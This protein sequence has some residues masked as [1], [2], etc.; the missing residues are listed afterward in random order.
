MPVRIVVGSRTK[1]K[2]RVQLSEIVIGE[3]GREKRKGSENIVIYDEEGKI[4]LKELFEKVNKT[5]TEYS[6]S[7]GEVTKY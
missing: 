6:K 4:D 5:V 7:K 2:I 3:K 1:K